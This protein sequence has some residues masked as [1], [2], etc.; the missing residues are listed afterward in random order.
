M[1]VTDAMTPRE[2]LVTVSLPGSRD[3]ALEH[4]RKREF[5]SVAVVKEE[6]SDETFRGLISREA[7]IENP[8][9][10]QLALLVEEG[11]TT[12]SDASLETLAEMMVETGARRVP[13][14]NGSGLNGIVTITDVIGAI[15]EGAA[16]GERQVSE[17]AT[18]SV[19]G[20][21]SG[22]PLRVAEQ[23][24]RY[25]D[26]PYAVVID[27]AAEPVGILTDADLIAVAEIVEGEDDTGGAMAGDDDEWM[28]EGI[29]TVGNRYYP[30][31]NVEFPD[32]TVADYMSDDLVTVS[33]TQTAR[34]A[35]QLMVRHDI[36]QIP[37]MSGGELLG[38]VQDMDLLHA[39]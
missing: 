28:W 16:D 15:A 1:D 24:L 38:I 30:T 19:N 18:R 4:L 12:S 23:E 20:I 13:V 36:E 17:L 10:D 31:R 7:L 29:K 6:N 27:D 37:L 3:A 26:T 33:R 25:A 8:D 2:E 32:G 21:Y 14:V 22:S 35:A 11:P 34:E 5:S 39:V 9:E